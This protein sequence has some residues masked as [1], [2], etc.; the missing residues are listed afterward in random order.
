MRRLSIHQFSSYRWSFFQDVIKY[1]NLGFDSIGLWRSKVDEFGF[2]EAADLLFE[3]KMTPSSLSWAGG[4]TGSDGNTFKLAVEDGVEAVYQAHLLGANNLIIHPGGRNRHTESHALRIFKNALRE[5]TATAQDLGIRLLIEPTFSGKS[6]WNFLTTVDQYADLLDEF[7]PAELGL[8]ID[9]FHIGRN[10]E[11]FN[12]FGRI[13]DRIGVVQISDGRFRKDE[14]VRCDLGQGI[15]PV[16]Q[17][18]SLLEQHDYS[19]QYEL[20]LHGYHFENADYESVIRQN[21]LCFHRALAG[22]RSS[23]FIQ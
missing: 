14:F 18:L 7:E 4:F 3:M 5:L 11:L 1:A 8:V 6:P 10:K 17:W 16:Q 12:Q 2:E 20:E 15:I 13:K 21:E 23:S 19:G 9:L 22:L